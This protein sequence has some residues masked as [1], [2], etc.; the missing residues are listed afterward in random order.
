MLGC[1]MVKTTKVFREVLQSKPPNWKAEKISKEVKIIEIEDPFGTETEF[2]VHYEGAISKSLYSFPTE[3]EIELFCNGVD[4]ERER[5]IDMLADILSDESLDRYMK[6]SIKIKEEH[7]K[8]DKELDFSKDELN[9]Y[10]K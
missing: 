3:K 7:Q 4:A 1:N 8:N 10:T 2:T 9:A 6:N 5:F